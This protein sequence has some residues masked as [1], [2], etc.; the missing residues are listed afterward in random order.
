MKKFSLFISII[1]LLVSFGMLVIIAD[2]KKYDQRLTIDV[3]DKTLKEVTTIKEEFE[4]I[5]VKYNLTVTI[6]PIPKEEKEMRSKWQKV[7]GEK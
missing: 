6:S 2:E 7:L 1:I 3:Y 5:A 4:K